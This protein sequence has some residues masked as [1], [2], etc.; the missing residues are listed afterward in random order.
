MRKMLAVFVTLALI[1]GVAVFA[2]AMLALTLGMR[3]RAEVAT[4]A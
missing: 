3:G 1:A 4:S 2:L